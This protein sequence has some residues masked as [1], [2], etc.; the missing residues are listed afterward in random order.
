VA[1]PFVDDAHYHPGLGIVRSIRALMLTLLRSSCATTVVTLRLTMHHFSN[2][3]LSRARSCGHYQV[4]GHR[5]D[6][7]LAFIFFDRIEASTGHLGLTASAAA[8]LPPPIPRA[9]RLAAR[10]ALVPSL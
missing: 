4:G 2:D 1:A 9:A 7:S 5:L 10:G 6:G 3:A 8:R